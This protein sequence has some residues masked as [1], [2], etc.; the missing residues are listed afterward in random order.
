MGAQTPQ[1]LSYSISSSLPDPLWP[2]VQPAGSHK[3]EVCAHLEAHR[4][5]SPPCSPCQGSWKAGCYKSPNSYCPA[6]L[7]LSGLCLPL[8]QPWEDRTAVSSGSLWLK[9]PNLEPTSS[10][11][12]LTIQPHLHCV[13]VQTGDRG[14]T[15]PE[16]A[17]FE[18]Q[19]TEW[20]NV[21]RR[22]V[23]G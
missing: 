7:K 21:I 4:F 23:L 10:G 12:Q 11:A 17:G 6:A 13:A 1:S 18:G 15:G 2:S 20:G 14:T 5:P 3:D 9:L 16:A 19:E 8:Q 22:P